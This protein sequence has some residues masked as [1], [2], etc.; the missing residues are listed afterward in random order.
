MYLAHFTLMI[1]LDEYIQ[2]VD[3]YNFKSNRSLDSVID[4]EY[5]RLD[6]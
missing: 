4:V 3:R 5:S 6:S 1:E 2:P